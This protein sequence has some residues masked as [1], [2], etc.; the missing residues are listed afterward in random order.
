M[1]EKDIKLGKT[2]RELRLRHAMTQTELAG[3][4]ITRNMLSLIESG[5][6]VPSLATLRILA[7]RLHVPMG[8]F[9]SADDEE[10]AQFL[11]MSII[12]EI[13]RDL[14]EGKYTECISLCTSVSHPD[15]EI[16]RIL[17]HCYLRL[18]REALQRYELMTASELLKKSSHIIQG[19]AYDDDS[20]TQTADYVLLLIHSVH[21]AELPEELGLPSAFPLARIPMEFRVYLRILFLFQTG[22]TSSAVALGKSG[23]LL[24]PAYRNLIAAREQIVSQNHAEAAALLH[25]ALEEKN[26]DFFTKAQIL[27]ALENC[28]SVSGDYREAY[29]YSSEKIK[30]MELFSQ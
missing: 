17:A 7:E 20:I 24:C 14:R 26:P 5:H 27:D 16:C 9:F 28:A 19:C 11:K 6:A 22:N 30:L 15:D 2:I 1:D 23:L 25:T 4:T 3:D 29:R 12:G 10:N 8:Y 13:R 21:H 18:S